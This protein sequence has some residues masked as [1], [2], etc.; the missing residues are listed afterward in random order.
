MKK[1]L[2]FDLDGTLIQSIEDIANTVIGYITKKFWEQYKEKGRYVLTTTKWTPLISQLKMILWAREDLKNIKEELYET[3]FSS[4]EHKFFPWVQAKIKDL[5]EDYILLL[6]TSNSTK[7]AKR[8]LENWGILEC[9]TEVLWSEEI[10]KGN[11]HIQK[12]E[13]MLQENKFAEKA[14][15]ISD[16]DKDREVAMRHKIDFIHIGNDNID[17][18]EVPNIKYIGSILDELNKKVW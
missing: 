3:I 6:S 1:Y 14:V 12:F 9:F 18:Y 17:K 4:S 11:D 13:E 8:I 7:Q 5:A 15:Y 10:L 16:G 2:I